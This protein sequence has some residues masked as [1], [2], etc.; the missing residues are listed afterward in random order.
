MVTE[1]DDDEVV[2][3]EVEEQVELTAEEKQ[4]EDRARRMGW[5]PKDEYGGNPDRWVDAK[6]FVERGETELPILRERFRKLD[7]RL[8]NTENRLK[9]TTDKLEQSTKV[10]VEIRDMSR[11]AEDRAYKRAMADLANKEREAVREASEEKYNAI[12]AEKAAV[13]A[14]RPKPEETVQRTEPP[15]PQTN[16]VI[17]QWLAD[18]GWFMQDR[19]LNAVAIEEDVAIKRDHPGWTVSEQLA[20]VRRRVVERFPEKFGSTRKP[21]VTSD[22]RSAPPAV[23]VSTASPP[24]PKGKTVKD[25][26]PEAREAL[27]RFKA[28]IPN[29]TEEEYLKTYFAGEE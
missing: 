15:V 2:T 1:N 10:L 5:R 28:S 11:T 18:N 25:L 9:D 20:E 21:P 7:D 13:E 24:R 6:T 19:V 12:Q 14:S 26:P 4:Y 29:Y 16:P 23:A 27:K 22:R 8:A 3:P 17:D